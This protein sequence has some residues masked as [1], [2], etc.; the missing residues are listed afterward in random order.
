MS[1]VLLAAAL[2]TGAPPQALALRRLEAIAL[3]RAVAA[4]DDAEAAG[5]AAAALSSRRARN[6]MLGADV[7]ARERE[8]ERAAATEPGKVDAALLPASDAPAAE[9]EARAR[10]AGRTLARLLDRFDPS[11]REG[12][13]GAVR[14]LD[15]LLL[16]AV[17]G[18]GIEP[19]EIE[20]SVK[21]RE[22]RR[23]WAEAG[24]RTP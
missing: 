15:D 23:A 13:R 7:V 8:I 17:A 11:W 9:G 4:T 21:E 5:W 1:A 12:S 16:D 3:D 10:A 24:A 22:W 6:A 19:A 2:A 18:L 14:A 20:E